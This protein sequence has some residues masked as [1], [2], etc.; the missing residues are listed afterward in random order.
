MEGRYGEPAPAAPTVTRSQDYDGRI[1][2]AS[3]NEDV[4]KVNAETGE[5]TIVGTGTA[6]I[7]VSGAETDY[8]LA[9]VTKTYTVVIA[10]AD[11]ITGTTDDK[12]ANDKYFDLQG[13]RTNP[14]GTRN[15]IY[16]VN[17]KIVVKR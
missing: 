6:I 11:G 2:F 15:D 1:T 5:L 4:V 14:K 7:S 17:G 12:A 9:P 3:S 8:R 10:E 13:R 16:V